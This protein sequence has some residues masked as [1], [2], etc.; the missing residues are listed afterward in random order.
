[1]VTC[2]DHT[3]N[4]LAEERN[5]NVEELVSGAGKESW[6]HEVI[7]LGADL[8]P[9]GRNESNGRRVK[10]VHIVQMLW[11]GRSANSADAPG[12]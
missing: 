2:P 5:Q 1:M 3:Q 6:I 8:A 11:A 9:K 12:E 10:S 7:R 4:Y